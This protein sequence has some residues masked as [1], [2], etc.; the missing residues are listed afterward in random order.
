MESIAI[1][2]APVYV[3][4]FFWLL[5]VTVAIAF[6]AFAIGRRRLSL[7]MFFVFITCEAISIW[8]SLW[9]PEVIYRNFV[10][11]P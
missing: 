4:V 1:G 10:G 5:P 9:L 8:L 2:P 6:L 3:A 7:T 11:E